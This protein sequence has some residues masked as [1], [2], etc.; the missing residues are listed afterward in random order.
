MSPLLF[1]TIFDIAARAVRYDNKIINLQ[2]GEKIKVS[3]FCRNKSVY[4]RF[5]ILQKYFLIQW[6]KKGTS[7]LVNNAIIFHLTPQIKFMIKEKFKI[8]RHILKEN[9]IEYMHV[10]IKAGKHTKRT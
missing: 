7:H 6:E 3:S 10:L 4:M 5:F 8:R 2:L 9:L 1:N